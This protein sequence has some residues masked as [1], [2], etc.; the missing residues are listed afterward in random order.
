MQSIARFGSL[1]VRVAL[2]GFP[3][4]TMVLFERRVATEGPLYKSE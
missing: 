2:P 1:I 3:H 4:T